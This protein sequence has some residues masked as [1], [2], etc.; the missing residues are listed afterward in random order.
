[1]AIEI[2]ALVFYMILVIIGLVTIWLGS[3]GTI[4]ILGA[5][6]VYDLLMKN[7]S[8]VWEVYII[9]V[10]LLAV[11]EIGDVVLSSYWKKSPKTVRIFKTIIAIAMVVA[12][13]LSL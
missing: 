11:G 13:V 7:A 10:A 4:F 5:A 2:F 9:L 1:M 6:L 3:P 12:F 8:L